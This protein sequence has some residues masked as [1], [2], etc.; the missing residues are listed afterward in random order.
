MM[1]AFALDMSVLDLGLV[2]CGLVNITGRDQEVMVCGLK[3]I[4]K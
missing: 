4:T 2:T 1:L 3:F